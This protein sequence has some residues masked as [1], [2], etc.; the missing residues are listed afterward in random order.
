MHSALILR[1]VIAE[2]S[3]A[4]P[5][6]QSK[7]R[8]SAALIDF[9]WAHECLAVGPEVMSVPEHRACYTQV[10]GSTLYILDIDLPSAAAVRYNELTK[11]YLHRQLAFV[12]LDE[13]VW[14]PVIQLA[15]PVEGIGM[16]LGSK[17]HVEFVESALACTAP[18]TSTR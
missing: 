18:K 16:E 5:H 13:V 2:H 8:N 7:S 3:H 15:F 10:I 4:C 6:E 12:V 17:S 1:P 11:K 9:P 14:A